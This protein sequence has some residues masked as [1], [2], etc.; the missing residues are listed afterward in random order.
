MIACGDESDSPSTALG[1]ETIEGLVDRHNFYRSE[2]GVEGIE[3]S[4][5]L[6]KSAQSWA[7]QLKNDCELVHSTSSYGEN[8]WMGTSG[9]FNVKDVVDS[10]GAEKANYTYADNSCSDVCGHYTQVVWEE[11]TKVGC[12][13]VTCN[14][15]DIWVCQYDPPGNFIGEKPY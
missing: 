10:W 15:F 3:W 7:N 9:A 5:A 6:A 13:V 4:E 14:G 1:K 2:V 8:L 12:G 11:S